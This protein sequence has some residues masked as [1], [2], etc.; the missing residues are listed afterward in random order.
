MAERIGCEW[1]F[2]NSSALK[3][4]V[5]LFDDLVSMVQP[6]EAV[7]LGEV[8]GAGGGFSCG[9]IGQAIVRTAVDRCQI[10]I[11]PFHCQL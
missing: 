5:V 7:F 1:I 10:Q 9:A 6:L 4:F 2:D 11:L 8:F 3:L